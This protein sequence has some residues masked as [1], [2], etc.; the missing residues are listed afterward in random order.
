VTILQGWKYCPR[1]RSGLE[2]DEKRVECPECGFVAYGGGPVPT[3]TAVVVDDEGRVLLGRRAVEPDKGRWD[4]PGGF[5]ED[6]EHPLDAV[7]REL[8]EETS[9]EIEPLEFIGIFMDKYGYDSGAENT[10]NLYWTARIVSGTMTPDDDVAELRWFEP[11]EIPWD[12]LAFE[13][14]AQVLSA[15]LGR[16]EHA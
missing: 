9:L 10:L 6:G 4:L 2:G 16:N 15:W 12:E 5:I 14:N 13:C 7:R 1:C 11:A 3:A 8:R